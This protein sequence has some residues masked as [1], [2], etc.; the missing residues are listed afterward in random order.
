[1]IKLTWLRKSVDDLS[2]PQRDGPSSRLEEDLKRE[3]R[4]ALPLGNYEAHQLV[5][6]LRPSREHE[7]VAVVE[8]ASILAAGK[9][10]SREFL[11]A[12]LLLLICQRAGCVSCTSYRRAVSNR[13][14]RN[15]TYP[16]SGL[17]FEPC[18]DR[19]TERSSYRHV[20][21]STTMKTTSH[22]KASQPTIRAS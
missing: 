5:G 6:P 9:E 18:A 7:L 11:S 17:R 3:K 10:P 16:L 20:T 4:A 14:P 12:L 2:H 8:L 15:P 21:T 22:K 13:D 1:M 19:T